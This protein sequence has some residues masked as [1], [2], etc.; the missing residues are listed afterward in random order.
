MIKRL[1]IFGL[2]VSVFTSVKAQIIISNDTAVCGVY[3]DTLYAIGANQDSI[4]ADDD[5][6]DLIQIGFPFTFY[7]LTY[8]SLVVCDNGYITFDA[9]QANNF[10]SGYTITSAVPLPFLLP[11]ANATGP[12]NAIM[13]PWHDVY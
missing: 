10:S 13:A 1:L 12:N 6:S 11:I 8:T 4:N 5:Y 2:I 9:Y 7:G 3:T